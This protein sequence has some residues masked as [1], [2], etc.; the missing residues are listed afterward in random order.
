MSQSDSGPQGEYSLEIRLFLPC[1][2]GR[3]ILFSLSRKK[4]GG[5]E[6][7]VEGVITMKKTDYLWH[8]QH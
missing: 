5:R 8:L 6:A 2:L 1:P 7:A 3:A 4:N